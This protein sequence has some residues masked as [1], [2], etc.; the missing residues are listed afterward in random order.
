MIKIKKSSV[1]VHCTFFRFTLKGLISFFILFTLLPCV[2]SATDSS[3]ANFTSSRSEFLIN[4]VFHDK[5]YV[6]QWGN[7]KNP[8]I[9]LVHGLG[10]NGARDWQYLAPEL[11]KSFYV[12]TFDLPGFG[13]S[14]KNNELYSPN[15]YAK[16][17][18][19]LASRFIRKPFVL[20]GHSMGGVIA[21]TYATK[22]RDRL[23]QLILVD[24]TG[25][26]FSASFS[27]SLLK[28]SKPS[29]WRD[30]LTNLDE[31]DNPFNFS[32]ED[33]NGVP[34]AI[35]FA[36]STKITRKIFL[37][38]NPT[39]IS[40]LAMVQKNFSGLLENMNVPT[41]IV[42]GDGDNIAPIR[43]AKLLDY[44]LPHSSLVILPGSGHTPM[45]DVTEAFNTLIVN[46]VM[47]PKIPINDSKEEEN[48]I[49]HGIV[50]CN[51]QSNIHYSGKFSLLTIKS[52]HKVTIENATISHLIISDSSVSIMRSHI[53]DGKKGMEVDDSNVSAT[54]TTL[55][56]DIAVTVDNSRLDFA[57]VSINAKQKAFSTTTAY[58]AM[59]SLCSIS[60]PEFTGYRHG[61]YQ[62][63]DDTDQIYNW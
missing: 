49:N 33:I 3:D 47:H 24:T 9:V 17:I 22:H 7:E 32:M 28:K 50:Q 48:K 45:L 37:G 53:G 60:S 39:R 63:P 43:T 41:L 8:A 54:A 40:G 61:I 1:F 30:L 57:G 31:M 55:S 56:G 29:L 26:L 52:C 2:S 23:K 25:I 18:D 13:R 4:P 62:T 59:F 12:I 19:W 6:E 10:E 44:L 15:N 58:K 27:K 14:A 21:L 36:L 38:A 11:A 51:H 16:V 35:D 42:W 46:T 5:L 20:V 34:E